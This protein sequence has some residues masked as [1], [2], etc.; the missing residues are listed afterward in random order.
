MAAM[1]CDSSGTAS[2][3]MF[4]LTMIISIF[5]INRKKQWNYNSTKWPQGNIFRGIAL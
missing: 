3:N 4:E 5:I 2:K 1:L